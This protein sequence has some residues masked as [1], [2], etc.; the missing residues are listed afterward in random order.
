[1][2]THLCLSGHLSLASCKHDVAH[3]RLRSAYHQAGGP[4]AWR[5]LVLLPCQTPPSPWSPCLALQRAPCACKLCTWHHGMHDLGGHTHIGPSLQGPSWPTSSW[6]GIATETLH[7]CACSQSPQVCGVSIPG[8]ASLWHGSHVRII[9]IHQVLPKL[10]GR[11]TRRVPALLRKDGLCTEISTV[12]SKS[13]GRASGTVKILVCTGRTAL[14]G[15]CNSQKET[16]LSCR[17]MWGTD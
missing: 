11:A 12:S 8:M 17:H 4:R 5:P 1:M 14:H 3:H 13:G 7:R 9:L 2:C 16:D 6:A 15:Y 10:A